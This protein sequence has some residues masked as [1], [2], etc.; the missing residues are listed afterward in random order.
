MENC[1]QFNREWYDEPAVCVVL[2]ARGYPGSY[3]KG[4]EIHGL[5]KL[6]NWQKGFVFHAGTVKDNDRWLTSGGRV[7]GVTARGRNIAQAVNECLS[8]GACKF[9]GTAC[10][11]ARTSPAGLNER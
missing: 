6:K 1:D 7:L 11:I 2:T 5:D 9:P 8:S 3:D 10:T 4:K